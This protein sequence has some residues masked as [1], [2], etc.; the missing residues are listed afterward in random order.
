MQLAWQ[1]AGRRAVAGDVCCWEESSSLGTSACA[2][3]EQVAEEAA[4]RETA[5]ATEDVHVRDLS[6][7]CGTITLVLV[8]TVAAFV[9]Q[10]LG[11][12]MTVVGVW[13]TWRD[14]AVEG[15]RFWAPFVDPVKR[16]VGRLRRLLRRLL[17]RPQ[18]V[19]GSGAGLVSVSATGSG[20]AV[21]TFP[22]LPNVDDAD[23]L[24]T[25]ESRL[26]WLQDSVERAQTR[27]SEDRRELEDADAALRSD[28]DAQITD[29]ERLTRQAAT[30]GLRLEVVG[31]AL[32]ALATVLQAWA[33]IAQ[34]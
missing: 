14:F 27:Q 24:V 19:T 28:L 11:L 18:V 20:R 34:R 4:R 22:P 7:L 5:R 1:R 10:V 6:A 30:G 13:Q 17:R 2:G 21:V 9:L 15:E 12:V 29:V 25:L 23:F 33:Q 16:S 3:S 26:R 31:V 8:V 32:V